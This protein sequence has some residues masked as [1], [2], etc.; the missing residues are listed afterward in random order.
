M[1]FR[2]EVRSILNE[3]KVLAKKYHS[4]T[5]KPLGITSEVA[6]FSAAD[7]L[8]LE[9]GCARQPG[10]DAMCPRKD[11][12]IQ[13]KGRCLPDKANPGAR[14]GRINLKKDWDSV[15]LVLMDREF[16]VLSIYEALRPAVEEALLTPGSKARNE[17]GALSVSKFRSISCLVW[18]RGGAKI[19]PTCPMC[20][21]RL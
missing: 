7:L 12:K 5:G 21:S 11:K 20:Q 18:E 2:E 16:E 15:M 8:N 4:L 13:I 3:A 17:R 6:E 10:F 1:S 14:I 19:C 9:L